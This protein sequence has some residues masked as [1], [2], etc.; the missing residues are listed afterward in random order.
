MLREWLG[1]KCPV[2][3]L[4]DGGGGLHVWNGPQSAN[5]DQA[6]AG[7]LDLLFCVRTGPAHTGMCPTQVCVQLSC[8]SNCLCLSIRSLA[9]RGSKATRL[10]PWGGWST[11]WPGYRV[12]PSRKYL[13]TPNCL[14]PLNGTALF[15]CI[16]ESFATSSWTP[17]WEAEVKPYRLTRPRTIVTTNA[18]DYQ[19]SYLLEAISVHQPMDCVATP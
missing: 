11:L 9:W 8:S 7:S 2:V 18:T 3:I 6:E 16:Q 17:I 10:K 13:S 15:Y 14:F 5:V 1:V 19:V 4:S 12:R